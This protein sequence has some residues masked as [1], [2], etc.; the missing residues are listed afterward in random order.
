MFTRELQYFHSFVHQKKRIDENMDDD[1][2]MVACAAFIVMSTL[3]KRRRRKRRW[4][5]TQLYRDRA[6]TRGPAFVQRLIEEEEDG[7]FQNFVRM[8]SVDFLFLLE[9]IRE[10]ISRMDTKL[11]KAI[12]VEER[13]AL[14]LR[15]LATGDSYSSL[16][17]TFNISKQLISQIVPE[18]CEA[19]IETLRHHVKV[20]VLFHC[21]Q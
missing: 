20:S 19:I 21:L 3:I 7:H 1:D 15:F 2:V 13:L 4:W 12:S 16:K 9:A 10:K 18:V 17:Y 14:T 11:R 6:L 8:S 5:M